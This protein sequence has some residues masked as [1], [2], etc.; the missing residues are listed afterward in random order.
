MVASSLIG[1]H[2]HLEGSIPEKMQFAFEGIEGA[3]VIYD[4]LLACAKPEESHEKALRNVL[5]IAQEKGVKLKKQSVKPR[6]LK[7]CTLA[8][9][10]PKI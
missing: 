6:Y 3:E 9:R 1:N 4:D 5:E 2:F 8:T 10:L 7:V